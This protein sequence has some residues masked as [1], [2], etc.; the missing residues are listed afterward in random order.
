MKSVV[1]MLCKTVK[2]GIIDVLHHP[3][4][5]IVYLLLILSMVYGFVSSF[6]SDPKTETLDLRILS[7]AYLA[8]L[9]FVSIP[10][11][12]KGLSMSG[13]FFKLSDVNNIFVAPISEKKV[14][15]YGIG[16]QV[17]TML[18]LVLCFLSYGSM[19]VKMF[20]ISA[21]DAILLIAGI[22]C[23]LILVQLM[24]ILVFCVCNGRAKI[25]AF[26]RYFIY[27]LAVYAIG[28]AIGYMFVYGFNYE[29][30][31]RAI[32]LPA[33]QYVPVIGWLH[34][35]VFGILQKN[36]LNVAVYGGLLA[37][38]TVVSVVVLYRSKPD[39]Y[40][41]VLQ[42]T[43]SYYEMRNAYLEGKVTESMLLGSKK[44][45]LRKT[46]I[47]RGKGAS[48]FFFKHIREGFRRS[49][50]PF[51]NVNTVV[52]LCV[53]ALIA[54]IMKTSFAEVPP[55]IIVLSAVI[56]CSYIQ[57]FFSMSGDW[58]KELNK[59]YIYLVPDSAVKKLIMAS[60]TSLIKPLTDSAV[61]FTLLG[62]CVSA[63]V[64]D[65]IT[66]VLVYTSFGCIY[67]VSNIMSQRVIGT[68]GGRSVFITFYMSF[69]LLVLIPGIAAGVFALVWL[70]GSYAYIAA[71]LMGVP[72]FIWNFFI[73]FII[74]LLCKNLL[75]NTE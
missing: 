3:S 44:I 71:T 74:F 28:T 65:I 5:L 14:L 73:S 18:F 46:G 43:E 16:R 2:N 37:V 72:I 40:E 15:V 34:G 50:C 17:A 41:D 25:S 69:I 63:N 55:T 49:R 33:L 29:N 36:I 35:L 22:L 1:Y 20:E 66:A 52:L 75:N 61:A 39:Y 26:V 31:L 67:L 47:N 58:V 12:L 24:T 4:K 56:I 11:V 42:K 45:K 48:T 23:M 68:N 21:A 6:M 51:F 19:A 10:V 53:A 38:F 70:S 27:F 13:G 8:I 7:G 9:Y 59:P 57:F 32:S 54:A 64:F 60:T 62:V 30:L